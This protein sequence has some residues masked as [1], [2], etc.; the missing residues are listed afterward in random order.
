MK[1]GLGARPLLESEIKEAQDRA[2]SAA[3]AA[4]IL[5]VSYT[6]YKKYA[7]MYGILDR[8]KN[9]AGVG[10]KKGFS[11]SGG[12]YPLKDILEGK[13]P[14]YPTWKVKSRLLRNG[15]KPEECECCGFNEKRITDDKVPLM[16]AYKNGDRTDHRWENIEILCYNCYFLQVGN[17]HGRTKEYLY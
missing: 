15:V 8:L 16:I 13:H 11:M 7:R 10:I 14:T 2:R 5:D 6:T 12:K 3:E 9:Q 4:R 1:R 17:I